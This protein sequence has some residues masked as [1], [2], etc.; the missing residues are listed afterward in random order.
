[1][2]RINKYRKA[3]EQGI[4]TISIFLSLQA[5]GPL[6]AQSL[7]DPITGS[8]NQYGQINSD[9][10]PRHITNGTNPHVG[11]DYQ[12]TKGGRAYAVAP[13]Q[14]T[15][16]YRDG[17]NGYIRIGNWRYF[18]LEAGSSADNT[19]RC[20][21]AKG[22]QYPTGAIV[23]IQRT[24]KNGLLHTHRVLSN[25]VFSVPY[26]D[27][28]TGQS[29]TVSNTVQ[30]GDW[31]FTSNGENHLHLDYS[32]PGQNG[33]EN[34]L[35]Y[36]A[37]S[38]Q[39][40]PTVFLFPQKNQGG[41]AVDFPDSAVYGHPMILN[42]M[43]NVTSDKDF[44]RMQLYFRE[45]GKSEQLLREWEY[46][47][48]GLAGIPIYVLNYSWDI[49][50]DVREGIYPFSTIP[51]QDY[52][53][54]HFYSRKDVQGNDALNNLEAEWPD[55][56]Y[57]FR[58]RGT[59]I[60]GNSSSVNKQVIL[61][62]FKP[63]I[64]G[65]SITADQL[66]Y[67]AYGNWDPGQNM[68]LWSSQSQG[69]TSSG[70]SNVNITIQTS[71]PMRF[72]TVDLANPAILSGMPNK[73]MSPCNT[74]KTAWSISI[75]AMYLNQAVMNGISGFQFLIFSGEDLGGNG[76]FKP[77]YPGTTSGTSFPRRNN[78]G[79]WT[80]S[81]KSGNDN[82]HGFYLGSGP[83]PGS[84][85][86]GFVGLPLSGTSPLSV[87]FADVSQGPVDSWEWNFGNGMLWQGQWAPAVEYV[88]N[89]SQLKTYSVSLKVG[90]GNG[91]TDTETRVN[92]ITVYPQN[93][94]SQLTA[95]FQFDQVNLGAPSVVNFINLSTGDGLQYQW[96]F[97]DGSNST[98]V[99]PVH[100]FNSPG[101]FD[102]K[103]KVTDQYGDIDEIE[104]VIYVYPQ[105]VSGLNVDFSVDAP[106]VAGDFTRF[107]NL[108]TGGPSFARHLWDYGDGMLTEVNGVPM[109]LYFTPG[110]Y[111]VRLEV[112]DYLDNLLGV[113]SKMVTI[114]PNALHDLS[115]DANQIKPLD[116]DWGDFFGK[117]VAT[118]GEWAFIGAPYDDDQ[119]AESG[120]VYVYRLGIDSV[121]QFFQKLKPKIGS[122]LDYFGFSVACSG[123][124][125]VAGAPGNANFTKGK[126]VFFQYDGTGWKE[127]Q[128]FSS[129]NQ[130][131]YHFGWALDMDG[132]LCVIG[133]PNNSQ[134]TTGAAWVFRLQSNQQW[135]NEAMF[136]DGS[137]SGTNRF[138]LDVAVS[139]N[140]IAII[141]DPNAG[142]DK[143]LFWAF[144][145]QGWTN[146][147]TINVAEA[148]SVDIDC[149]YAV[150]GDTWNNRLLLY[151]YL[152][153]NWSF[154]QYLYP[155]DGAS[156]TDDFGDDVQIYG[157]YILAGK[158]GD[159][160]P[161]F[162]GGSAY[163][164]RRD[165][166]NQWS[167]HRKIFPQTPDPYERYG[168]ALGLSANHAISGAWGWKDE[169]GTAYLYTNITEPCDR[170]HRWCRV[171][172]YSSDD[173][174]DE[175]GLVQMAGDG[176]EVT[177][178]SGAR[179]AHIAREHCL[180][181]GFTAYAGSEAT[182]SSVN[183]I[184]GSTAIAKS[185]DCN[186]PTIPD[187][188]IREAAQCKLSL[189]PN[190]S[191]AGFTP[192][193]PGDAEK[194]MIRVFD[195]RGVLV[196]SGEGLR[197]E[198]IRLNHIPAGLYIVEVILGETRC[199]RRWVKQ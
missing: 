47:H 4:L 171:K 163:L 25:V 27:S 31:I 94:S 28:L 197:G 65:I 70:L 9:Y 182:F 50:D 68:F 14:I 168:S 46:E 89:T 11:I 164:F 17:T 78:D 79:S 121:W 110:I 80:P 43:M 72:V 129:P 93:S 194:A 51:S 57:I 63:F 134:L 188:A 102:V 16:I 113:K 2:G 145:G 137:A 190:P 76:F 96:D 165:Y 122:S 88:N 5:G 30:A 36:I 20:A 153:G 106:A 10:G 140:H 56:R 162:K 49:M 124:W 66:L 192:D 3:I 54:Y 95:D 136:H 60:T 172:L 97:D 138:G 109:H 148:S 23:I 45:K 59:D 116:G 24:T 22:A 166:Y 131:K 125:M 74:S 184:P 149:P 157:R 123:D 189:F 185:C 120:S 39:H 143:L 158:P 117:A 155:E 167:Q 142:Q 33:W 193:W 32:P 178:Y 34:P 69:G 35:R 98:A 75:P 151:D 108:T 62:N 126:A 175:A 135:A 13:G 18:H 191:R 199:A 101:F 104:K 61:D 87:Q 186:I 81:Q 161:S 103:L 180:S 130:V 150:L 29:V 85:E 132:P 37:H 82:N 183:C 58:V 179:A 52:M 119:G 169:R 8:T 170:E 173:F 160:H 21:V 40:S 139:A 15:H 187:T 92:Y 99:S 105:I 55:G 118:D 156:G 144:N 6:Q 84:L 77:Q 42:A 146:I 100:Q 195:A 196:F 141:A 12:L 38:D 115:T 73:Q 71:E 128:T 154:S 7:I 177:Y 127:K 152:N 133:A 67:A 26:Y 90:D 48:H 64:R 1:M 147:K 176:C 44:N 181:A 107:T 41:Q 91:N 53:K 86:A 198:E 174:L 159:M 114:I 112:R 19:W 111:Q 83:N